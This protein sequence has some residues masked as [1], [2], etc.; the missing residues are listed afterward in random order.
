MPEGYTGESFAG[1]L[2]DEAQVAV[3]QGGG[4]GAQGS[5]YIR[6][7]LVNSEDKLNEAV[8]RIA[9]AGIFKRTVSAWGQEAGT[10]D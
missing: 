6:L 7:S 2:L 3:A 10:H 1:R 8:D 5:S 9:A 4:F